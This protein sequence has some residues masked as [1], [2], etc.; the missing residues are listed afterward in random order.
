MFWNKD[1]YTK[2]GLDPEKAADDAARSSP[3]RP[4]TIQASSAATST[5]RTSAAT[6]AAACVFTFWP[7]VWAAGGDVHERRRHRRA[8]S[9]SKQMKPTSRDLRAQ[10]YD[11]GVAHA[12][13]QGRGRARPGSARFQTGKVGI[14]PMPSTTLGHDRGAGHQGRR[15]ARSPA[16]TAA[17]RR[18]S[19]AT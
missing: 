10:L 6:A 1:L 11:D 12:G 5:A 8:R 2:A 7:S 17:S 9:T 13:L 16:R 18:S 14:V 19:A 4:A 15:R 3:S